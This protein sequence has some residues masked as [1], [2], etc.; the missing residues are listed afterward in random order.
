MQVGL[1]KSQEGQAKS[2]HAVSLHFSHGKH[3]NT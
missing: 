1:K 2:G 3:F